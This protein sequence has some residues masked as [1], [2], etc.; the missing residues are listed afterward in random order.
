MRGNNIHQNLRPSRYCLSIVVNEC[1]NMS[2]SVSS[3][4]IVRNLALS[5]WRSTVERNVCIN[6]VAFS[7][8]SL[9]IRAEDGE[10]DLPACVKILRQDKIASSV[11]SIA[12]GWRDVLPKTYASWF[13]FAHCLSDV[14]HVAIALRVRKKLVEQE[15]H[16]DDISP[17]A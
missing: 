11:S 13:G 2:C 12:S 4:A 17:D 15:I 6:Q 5:D 8:S 10:T 7:V 16:V 1:C 3:I 14:E 9:F